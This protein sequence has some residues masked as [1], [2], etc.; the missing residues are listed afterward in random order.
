MLAMKKH[1][2]PTRAEPST[3]FEPPRTVDDID[4]DR[5]VW[6]PEYRSAVGPL[7]TAMAPAPPAS[8][9]TKRRG[10]RSRRN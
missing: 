7:L 6:D 1:R 2:K 10:R 3:P 4:L 8:A 9:A 5:V